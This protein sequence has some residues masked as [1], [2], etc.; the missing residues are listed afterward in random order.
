MRGMLAARIVAAA[1]VYDALTT[2]RP[3]KP[4]F[5]H[6]EAEAARRHGVELREKA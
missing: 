6:A 1:D 5:S 3:Y 2:A 4:A